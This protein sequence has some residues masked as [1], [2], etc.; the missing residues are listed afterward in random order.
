MESESLFPEQLAGQRQRLVMTFRASMARDLEQ[1]DCLSGAS[2]VWSMWPAETHG[3]SQEMLTSRPS[4]VISASCWVPSGLTAKRKGFQF[5]RG[6][7]SG[8]TCEGTAYQ[9]LGF[10]T[11][12]VCIALGNYHN[13]AARNRI[14]AEYVSV[15]DACGMAS[16]LA[17][18]ASS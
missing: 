10:Q 3:A 17:R 6:L 9:E 2:A 18:R 11:A 1:A 15:A 12:A 8:G 14:A 5:Q 4:S 7:M 13:C 16:S